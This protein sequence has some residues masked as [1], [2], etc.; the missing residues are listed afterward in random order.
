MAAT[1]SRKSCANFAA[2]P[3]RGLMK[4]YGG[5]SRI[6]RERERG[7][8]ALEVGLTMREFGCWRRALR[9]WMPTGMMESRKAYDIDL[10]DRKDIS[11]TLCR[12]GIILAARGC[13]R[14]IRS[15]FAFQWI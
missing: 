9:R 11:Y 8:G 6:E 15:R 10:M 12:V 5:V 13:C 3:G 7:D 1:R 4:I 14:T 2:G